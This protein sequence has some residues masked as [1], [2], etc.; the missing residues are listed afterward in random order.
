MK[1][2]QPLGQRFTPQ[3]III[4]VF[5]AIFGT[6]F[7]LMVF[8]HDL[9]IPVFGVADATWGVIDALTMAIV[10]TTLIYFLIQKIQDSEHRLQQINNT[11][12]DAIV[13]I[14]EQGRVTEWNLAAQK[15]FLYSK[16][17]AVGQQ[18]HQLI[19]P[20]RYYADAG[21][22]FAQFQ[23]TGKGP[24]IGMTTELI[25]LR[26]DGSEF[27][28][29]LSISTAQLKNDWHIIGIIRDITARKQVEF[30]LRRSEDNLHSAQ[31]IAHIGSWTLDIA[32]CRLEWSAEAFRIFGVS[33][34]D[35]VDLDTFVSTLHP[36][37]RDRVLKS[38]KEAVAGAT[39]DIEHRIVVGGEIRWVRERAIVERD[40]QGRAL[41]GIGTAQDVTER[42]L[43]EKEVQEMLDEANQSRQVM[44]GVIEDQRRAEDTLH[45]LNEEL[46]NKVAAR[47]HELEQAKAM[48]EDA[49][50]AK[51][52]FVANMSHEIRTPLN[53]IVGLTH[54]LRRGH[55]NPAQEEK[56]DKIVN[57][58]QHLLSVIN[59]ILDFSKIEA[60]KLSLNI[61]DFSFNRMLDNVI[62]MIGPEVRDK[63][64]EI[65]VERDELPSVLVGD[66]TRVAQ[67]LLN[68]LSNAVKFTERGQITVRLSKTEETATDLL[69]RF[70]VTDTGIGIPP[71]KIANLFA[72]FEQVDV[73]ISR[74][75]GGT[76]LGL[77]ITRRLARLMG[78]EAG[79]QS[80]PGQGS[81]F[82][83][84]V[85]LGKSKLSEKELAEA[86]AVSE[87]S[88]QAM[89]KGA[90]ILLAEDNK[91]NQEVAVEL[92]HEVGL[93]VEVA[94]DGYEALE[95]V[96]NG[97]YDL[98]LMDMQMPGM[99]G[100]DATRA[101]RQLPDCAT[102]PILAMTANVFDED[103]ERCK[104][105]GMN[106][107]I[108]KPVDPEKLFGALLRW[109]PTTAIIRPIPPAV[110][111]AVADE[112]AAI[113]G[114]EAALGLK[115]LNGHLTTYKRLLRRY[116]ADHAGDIVQL[117]ECLSR[118]DREE[119]R[120][121]AHTL[122]GSSSNLGATG[123]QR[124]AAELEM[125]IRDGRDAAEIG[126][127]AGTVETVL[128]RLIAGIR[129]ALPEDAE[130]LYAGE[131]DWTAVRQILDK[132]EPM[133]VASSVQANQVFETHAAQLK[134]ALGALGEKLEQ[135]IEHFL[136]PEAWEILKQARKEHSELAT[137][138]DA[139]Q[140][141]GDRT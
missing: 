48:A 32:T 110:A 85:R 74:R 98:I 29:E 136:Y 132:L 122:K 62:S 52:T 3:A 91:I 9:L 2:R 137:Q 24:L 50:A 101:I 112:L 73:T 58:S 5:V 102:L 104:A 44:L 113:P 88:L 89:P 114:L 31:A 21:R 76:G 26:K 49:N 71:E 93:Q 28:V 124:C 23:K 19:V 20:P 111:E 56:L 100:L 36:D 125:A 67:A 92:L 59:D 16:K 120:R 12:Q 96:R 57:A 27:P 140:H 6:E 34:R 68:Y 80:V 123:V 35:A 8:I 78:G 81:T 87:Q 46:E 95:K 115:V 25:A 1:N 47:T 83:F 38:W 55:T 133:L 107:F 4:V 97:G 66:S 22:G 45:L 61:A 119:A 121:L 75:F 11:A 139:A 106:D 127:L 30:K 33:I 15:I 77:A 63:H 126:Q 14:N 17:E 138:A 7:L 129:T 116:A 65:V 135:E 94:N 128:Q 109:L 53:A 41:F 105:A 79:A 72:A 43:R 42:K 103:R 141:S 84:T 64:L 108:A 69:L 134:A 99:D 13:V 10:I 70:E 117:R 82:W 40:A 90:R 37:D 86:P 54:L 39:Y 60:G 18:L 51:S 131:L 118:G 130:A